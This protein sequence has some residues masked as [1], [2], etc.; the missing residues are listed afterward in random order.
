VVV[1]GERKTAFDDG[2]AL[3]NYGFTGFRKQVL[4][5]R[6]DLVG[7]LHL[8]TGHTDVRADEGVTKDVAANA[9]VAVTFEPAPQARTL[10]I[11][12][13]ERVGQVVATSNGTVLAR[14]PAVAAT[15]LPL[16]RPGRPHP[17]DHDGPFDA[18]LRV[19]QAVARSVL[20]PFLY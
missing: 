11:R 7:S 3:L 19:L 20:G 4:F 8:A 6:G 9:T 12:A 10:P 18:V 2:A 17:P 16:P 5:A 15:A 13:G 14:A 1:L